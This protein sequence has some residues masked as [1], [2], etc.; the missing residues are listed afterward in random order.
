M[1]NTDRLAPVRSK[2]RA[3]HRFLPPCRWC[4]HAC[5]QRSRAVFHIQHLYLSGHHLPLPIMVQTQWSGISRVTR[6]ESCAR[7][8]TR[9]RAG[10]TYAPGGQRLEVSNRQRDVDVAPIASCITHARFS[11]YQASCI[12]VEPGERPR[13]IASQISDRLLVSSSKHDTLSLAIVASW[14]RSIR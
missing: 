13:I 9:R 5:T 14:I 6:N 12:S 10:A 7:G 3:T 2:L 4:G 1:N 8:A 11:V